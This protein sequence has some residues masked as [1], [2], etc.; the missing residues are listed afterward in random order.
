MTPS[1]SLSTVTVVFVTDAMVLIMPTWIIYD[2]QMAIKRKFITI[3]FLS[4]GFIVM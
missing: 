4:L 1:T 3:A 2:L